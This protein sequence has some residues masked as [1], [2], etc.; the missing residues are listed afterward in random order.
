M[1]IRLVTTR[2]VVSVAHLL[3]VPDDAAPLRLKPPLLDGERGTT[4]PKTKKPVY[5]KPINI[6]PG[7][8]FMATS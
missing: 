6:I 5:P 4:R 1:G 2:I 3:N 7:K 8:S